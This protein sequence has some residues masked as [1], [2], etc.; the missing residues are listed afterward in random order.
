MLCELHY[1]FHNAYIIHIMALTLHE[2]LLIN[3]ISSLIKMLQFD[4]I[5]ATAL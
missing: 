1:I 5:R 4:N 2:L 3:V